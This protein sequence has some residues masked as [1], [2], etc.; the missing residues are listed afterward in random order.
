MRF[1]RQIKRLIGARFSKAVFIHYRFD[2]PFSLLKRLL[3]FDDFTEIPEDLTILLI[4]DYKEISFTACSLIWCGVW[5]YEEIK[6][7][8]TGYYHHAITVK[9]LYNYLPQC[10]TKYILKLD[11][12][13]V[14]VH[15]PL[16]N[17]ISLLDY[18]NC[19]LLFSIGGTKELCAGVFLGETDYLKGVIEYAM[20]YVDGYDW[21]N[22]SKE[23]WLKYRD[24]EGRKY[25]PHGYGDQTIFR[26]INYVFP[27]MKLDHERKLAFR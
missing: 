19:K 10:R 22:K 6:V 16:D 7:K 17:I 3:S 23:E 8:H 20:Q 24:G 18:Y 2:L 4:N 25:L 26:F 1:T 21:E 5:D 9:E 15:R 11:S 14:M 12:A 13:D 27:D